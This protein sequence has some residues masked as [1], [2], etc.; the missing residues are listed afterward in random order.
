MRNIYIFL[1]LAF[2]T[3]IP[4][5]VHADE[6]GGR[7]YGKTPAGLQDFTASDRTQDIAQ[8]DQLAGELQKIAPASGEEVRTHEPT[9]N[10]TS[11][12]NQ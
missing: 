7:F 8:D 12:Q 3:L 9:S 4:S 10:E 6:F 2:L 5:L 11:E 1:T